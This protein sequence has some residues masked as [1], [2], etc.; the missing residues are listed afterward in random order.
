MASDDEDD[1]FTSLR[2]EVARERNA[3]FNKIMTAKNGS[4]RGSTSSTMSARSEKL[5]RSAVALRSPVNADS[6]NAKP[7]HQRKKSSENIGTHQR[8]NSSSDLNKSMTS[9]QPRMSS[10]NVSSVT[11]PTQTQRKGSAVKVAQVFGDSRL[12]ASAPKSLASVDP[13]EDIMAKVKAD[14]QFVLE[15]E[16]AKQQ[17][18]KET[19]EARPTPEQ[20]GLPESARSKQTS[21]KAAAVLG[22]H[23]LEREMQQNVGGLPFD[24]SNPQNGKPARVLGSV[25]TLAQPKVGKVLGPSNDSEDAKTRMMAKEARDVE[26]KKKEIT[27]SAVASSLRRRLS[28]GRSMFS[29]SSNNKSNNAMVPAGPQTGAPTGL[30]LHPNTSPQKTTRK[31]LGG[32]P[33][34]KASSKPLASNERASTPQRRLLM[35][36]YS[37]NATEDSKPQQAMPHGLSDREIKA[38]QS[39]EETAELASLLGRFSVLKT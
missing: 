29:S 11:S 33:E 19:L 27:T 1:D 35:R 18:L 2:A 28:A 34:E 21:L 30:P 25:S 37:S 39:Q 4:S 16:Q 13:A 36:M 15:R 6:Q 14:H 8:K 9:F 26:T 24:P 38:R 3:L 7:S 23:E 12:V 20:L 22:S 5:L 10:I 31:T 32:Q 17:K